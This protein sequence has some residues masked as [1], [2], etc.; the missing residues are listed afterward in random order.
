MA[1]RRTANRRRVCKEDI[2]LIINYCLSQTS[3]R[4]F[5]VYLVL[6]MQWMKIGLRLSEFESVTALRYA[7]ITI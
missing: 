6:G 7:L 4:R 5:G 2:T 1:E 3:S